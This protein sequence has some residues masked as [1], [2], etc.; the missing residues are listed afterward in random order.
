VKALTVRQPWASLIVR[1]QK[2]IENRGWAT[3]H[4]GPLLIHA[5]RSRA[6][7]GDG[8]EGLPLGAVVGLVS[9]TD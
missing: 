2:V 1:G 6:D 5:G 3:D 7:L 4:R 9:V 8:D